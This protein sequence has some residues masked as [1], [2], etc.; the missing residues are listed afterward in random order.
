[1]YAGRTIAGDDT[2]V[3]VT[4]LLDGT[5][6]RSGTG[7]AIGLAGRQRQGIGNATYD[8]ERSFKAQRHNGFF[9]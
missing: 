7:I 4:G 1:M 8:T 3:L 9:L 2:G 5:Y 6:G